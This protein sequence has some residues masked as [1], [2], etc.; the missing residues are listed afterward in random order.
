MICHFKSTNIQLTV[1]ITR[2]LRARSPRYSNN[3][4]QSNSA[5]G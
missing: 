3:L 2:N 5:V 1:K 4:I